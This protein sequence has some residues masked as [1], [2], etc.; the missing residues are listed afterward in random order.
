M[1]GLGGRTEYCVGACDSDSWVRV[2]MKVD[3]SP[4]FRH[5]LFPSATRSAKAEVAQA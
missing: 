4:T 1:V 5:I 3:R 2:R